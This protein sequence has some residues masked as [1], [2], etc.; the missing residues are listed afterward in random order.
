MHNGLAQATDILKHVHKALHVKHIWHWQVQ[1]YD[2]FRRTV[3]MKKNIKLSIKE[4]TL[5]GFKVHDKFHCWLCLELP[6]HRETLRE[7]K[8]K[9]DR[10]NTWNI[11]WY[12]LNK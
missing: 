11:K 6:G 1:W 3:I 2:A 12:T 5:W 4:I 8:K 10:P 7:Y 9:V